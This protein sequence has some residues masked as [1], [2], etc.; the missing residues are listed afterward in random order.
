MELKEYFTIIKKRALLI[1]LIT[2]TVTIASGVISYFVIKPVYKSDI[3][4]II[5]KTEKN[6]AAISPDYNDVMMY[7]T[8]VQTYSEFA[9]SRT[10]AQDV[11]NKLK[12]KSLKAIDLIKMITVAPTV[13]TEFLTITVESNDPK[14]S[15]GNC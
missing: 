3:S 1:V 15:N 10:V 11:I 8:M 9:T 5:G 4:V 12:L 14:E 13:N 2:L 7:Q 6:N